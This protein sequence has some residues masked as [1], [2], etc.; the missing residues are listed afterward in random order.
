M[1]SVTD[2]CKYEYQCIVTIIQAKVIS[3]HPVKKVKPKKSGYGT[4]IHVFM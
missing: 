4:A 2:T 1:D 3:G